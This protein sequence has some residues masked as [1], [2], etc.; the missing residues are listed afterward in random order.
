MHMKG[1][2]DP[3]SL[4]YHV[5]SFQIGSKGQQQKSGCAPDP[6]LPLNS[7][8]IFLSLFSFSFSNAPLSLEIPGFEL[9][10]SCKANILPLEPV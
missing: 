2:W 8:G 7:C 4:T 5:L 10:A 3:V 9:R 1:L 6:V